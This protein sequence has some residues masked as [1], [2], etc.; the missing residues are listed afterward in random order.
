MLNTTEALQP[1]ADLARERLTVARK[2]L[3]A[4]RGKA[5]KSLKQLASRGRARGKELSVL[6]QRLRPTGKVR[7]S[8][9]HNR[10]LQ[11]AGIATWGQV[12]EISRELNRISKKLDALS[13][14]K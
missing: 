12:R 11:A 10:L 7:L 13:S 1:A 9:W 14:T 3:I 6:A 8:R 2:R 5:E 4:L